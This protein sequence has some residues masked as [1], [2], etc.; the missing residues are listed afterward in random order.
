MLPGARGAH[1][2]SSAAGGQILEEKGTRFEVFHKPD[3]A[4][5]DKRGF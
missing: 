2:R 5:G 1:V 4:A 3:G